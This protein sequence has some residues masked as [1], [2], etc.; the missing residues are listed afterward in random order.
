MFAEAS[1]AA[2]FLVWRAF[3]FA[4][5]SS[6]WLL[7]LAGPTVCEIWDEVTVGVLLWLRKKACEKG[8]LVRGQEAM[9]LNVRSVASIMRVNLVPVLFALTLERDTHMHTRTCIHAHMCVYMHT[10]IHAHLC[11]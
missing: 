3:A 2:A 5:A 1:S 7:S 9:F 10:C 8:F 11:F 6:C 4:E